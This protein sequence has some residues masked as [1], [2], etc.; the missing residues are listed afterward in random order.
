[1]SKNIAENVINIRKRILTAEEMYNRSTGSVNL[2]AVSKTRSIKEIQEAHQAGVHEFGESYLQ[3]ALPKISSLTSLGIVWHFIGPIQANKTKEI[4]THF[5]WAHSVDRLKIA[6]RLSEQR[7]ENQI[8]LNICLQ[9]NIS[10]ETSKS[11][12]K[13][14]EI[15]EIANEINQ[16]SG[17]KLRGLMA[18]P[19]ATENFAEQREPFHRL[20]QKFNE[21]KTNLPTLDTLSMGMSQDLEAAIAEGATITRIGTAIF[22]PRLK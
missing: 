21:L 2:I 10:E 3:E 19:A 17:V 5:H 18:I 9:L 14:N 4:A 6:K 16:Y 1:M 22:G 11:G 12:F 15:N 13:I 7:P 8:P 20:A